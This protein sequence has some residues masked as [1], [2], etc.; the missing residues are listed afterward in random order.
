MVFISDGIAHSVFGGIGAAHYFGFNIYAGAFL[1]GIISSFLFEFIV[2]RFKERSDAVIGIILAAGMAAGIIFIY[3]TPGYTTDL[4]GYLFGNILMVSRAELIFIALF[5]ILIIIFVVLY[6]QIIKT[7]AFDYDFSII[8]GLPV[9]KINYCM[10]I[11]I[12]SSIILLIKAAGIILVIA[13]LTIPPS[14][15]N[16]IFKDLKKIMIS[17]IILGLIFGIAGLYFSFNFNLPAGAVIVV[18]SALTYFFQL[19]ICFFLRI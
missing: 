13:M 16:K 19:L 1:S 8:C 11:L 4:F 18:I 7:V 5:N 14:I 15:A 2:K 12:T 9:K 6:F 3:L 17:S 10:I